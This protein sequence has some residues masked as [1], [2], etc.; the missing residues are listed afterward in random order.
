MILCLACSS[1]LKGTLICKRI[2]HLELHTYG[3]IQFSLLMP[4]LED[5]PKLRSLKLIQEPSFPKR[6]IKDQPSSVAECLRSHLKTLEW[7]GYAG[8]LVEAKEVAAYIL[9]NAHCLKTATITLYSTD[10][11]TEKRMLIQKELRSLTKASCQLVI[12]LMDY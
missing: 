11:D 2:L 5:S 9:K 1:H 6:E 4:L 12:L 7:I 3:T 8:T 10:T